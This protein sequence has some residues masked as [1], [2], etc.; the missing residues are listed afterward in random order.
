MSDRKGF[1]IDGMQIGFYWLV[2]KTQRDMNLGIDRRKLHSLIEEIDPKK[3][4]YYLSSNC[5]EAVG[6]FD[7]LW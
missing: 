4:R 3:Y 2:A 7:W 6:L 5:A 1:G